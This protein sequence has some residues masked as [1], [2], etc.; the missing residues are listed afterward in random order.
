[1]RQGDSLQVFCEGLKRYHHFLLSC[2]T[3]PEGDAVGTL[4]AVDSLLRRLGKKTTIVC[5]DPFPKRLSCLP[6][7]RWRV[8]SE[9]SKLPDFDAAFLADCASLERVGSVR[10]LLTPEKVIFNLDHHVSNAFFGQ[11][12]YIRPKAAATGEV[13]VELF[14]HFKLKLTKEE[15]SFLYIAIATDTGSFRFGA[16]IKTH[17]LVCELMKTGISVEKIQ[18][19]LYSTYSLNKLNLYGRLLGRVKISLKGQI[20]WASMRLRDLE[21]SGTTYEDAEGFIDFLR[22]IKEVKVVFFITE[23][24]NGRGVKVSF[25]SK[26]KQD[27]NRIAAAFH[28]GGH[29]K[30]A[31][32]TLK[33]PLA[34]VEKLV[35]ERLRKEFKE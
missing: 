32:C 1:M 7:E 14:R 29:R 3:N 28:G 20:A 22:A 30:A 9:F 24:P 8:L 19:E 21:K 13:A 4:L 5:E 27:V 25:R 15:A 18:E 33:L 2:H 35:L 34:Q 12:N 6:S 10:D 23:L 11:Y 17:E 26:G 16:T 31:G